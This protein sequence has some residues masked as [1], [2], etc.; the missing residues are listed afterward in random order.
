MSWAKSILMAA[1]SSLWEEKSPVFQKRGKAWEKKS[2]LRCWREYNTQT[3]TLQEHLCVGN[4]T[5]AMNAMDCG[6]IFVIISCYSV[7]IVFV[8][9]IWQ[10][11]LCVQYIT[12]E[13][14]KLVS[15]LP[16][17]WL[18]DWPDGWVEVPAVGVLYIYLCSDSTSLCHN[19]TAIKPQIA[20]EKTNGFVTGGISKGDMNKIATNKGRVR[21]SW[22]ELQTSAAGRVSG[23]IID[24]GHLH[25]SDEWKGTLSIYRGR[26]NSLKKKEINQE[27]RITFWINH[28]ISWLV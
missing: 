10:L 20:L 19:H 17:L 22:D 7:C 16:W 28:F 1:I 11:N 23:V 2:E 8:V 26:G 15:G 5:P 6:S 3:F 27:S 12:Q 9:F 18:G 21:G 13:D 25:S 14:H 4:M 24:E